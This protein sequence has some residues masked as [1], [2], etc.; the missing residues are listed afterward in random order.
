M[1][2]DGVIIGTTATG[3][4]M[5]NKSAEWEVGRAATGGGDDYL[6]GRCD[7]VRFYNAT[8]TAEQ[9]IKNYQAGLS[10]HP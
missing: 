8:L 5:D 7:T 3:G 1:Y 10:A 4:P 9:I 2:I 6:N